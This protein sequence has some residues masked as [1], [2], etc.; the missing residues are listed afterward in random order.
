MMAGK[1]GAASQERESV[2]IEIFFAACFHRLGGIS[3]F[4]V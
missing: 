2:A 1:R 3:I 4:K